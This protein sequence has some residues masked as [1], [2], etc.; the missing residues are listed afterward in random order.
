MTKKLA[1][2]AIALAVFTTPAFADVTLIFNDNGMGGGT[3]TSGEY[4]PGQSFTFDIIANYTGSPPT[5]LFGLSLWFQSVISGT[6]TT[7]GNLFTI[8]GVNRTSSPFTDAQSNSFPQPMNT[9]APNP[10]PGDPMPGTPADNQFDL[11]AS[12]PQGTANGLMP[13]QYF[14][15]SMT[16]Q[17]TGM[18]QPG[19]V[20]DIRNVFAPV[21]TPNAGHGSV[22]FNKAGTGPNSSVDI[23]NS[24]YTVTIIPEPATWSLIALGG[25]A[26]A[27]LTAMR[28]RRR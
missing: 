2:I 13:G 3:A 8:T 1:S 18:V 21:G 22:A 5:D 26:C 14:V 9:G 17:I 23:P 15:M 7:A 11:G 19:Q 12:L 24:I 4:A 20:Y 16:I 10:P 28:R 6:N 25:L 27:G